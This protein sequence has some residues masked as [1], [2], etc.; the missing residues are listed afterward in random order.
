MDHSSFQSG[1]TSTRWYMS[2]HLPR[3]WQQLM[4]WRASPAS[5]S[6]KPPSIES[7]PQYGQIRPLALM[8]VALSIILSSPSFLMRLGFLV[9]PLG[10]PDFLNLDG[11]FNRVSSFPEFIDQLPPFFRMRT[12]VWLLESPSPDGDRAVLFGSNVSIGVFRLSVMC[13]RALRYLVVRCRYM[14]SG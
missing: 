13:R 9:P 1:T 6:M 5:T 14:R 11:S 2:C 7:A 3:H 4:S 8:Y 10:D 12:W